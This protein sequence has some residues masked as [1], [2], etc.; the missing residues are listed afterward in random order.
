MCI[1]FS[2]WQTKLHA[3]FSGGKPQGGGIQ[4][5][6]TEQTQQITKYEAFRIEKEQYL[7]SLILIQIILK[8]RPVGYISFITLYMNLK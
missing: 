8:V 5:L 1:V 7:K 4:M 6:D 3:D 2:G